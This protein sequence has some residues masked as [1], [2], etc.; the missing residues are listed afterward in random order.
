VSDTR[1]IQKWYV[2]IDDLIGGFDIGTVSGFAHEGPD[3]E[4]IA[5]GLQEH[6]A[7]HIVRLHN[8]WLDEERRTVPT[9]MECQH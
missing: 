3:R 7:E 6:I 9:H 4:N 8:E 1:I 2:N 5:W